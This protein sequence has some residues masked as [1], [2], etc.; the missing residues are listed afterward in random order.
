M[1]NSK[2]WSSTFFGIGVVAVDLVDHHDRLGA[3][4]E[5]LAQDEA[6]LGLRTLGGVD[7]Q[8]HAVDHV[9]DPF[10]L[11]AEVGVARGVDDV[12]VVVLVFE[13]GVLGADGDAL[14]A[15]EIHGIHDAF[16]GGLGLVG[17]EGAGLLEQAIDERRLAV[18]DV[19]DDREVADMLHAGGLGR[20]GVARS[21][22]H[23]WDGSL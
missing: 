13:G 21:G 23:G 4:L 12:D 18:V 7:D 16:L 9:H 3:G 11:A 19:R 20:R 17:A 5:G 6:G 15:L 22:W 10:D 1:K 2:T 14:L 8:Q